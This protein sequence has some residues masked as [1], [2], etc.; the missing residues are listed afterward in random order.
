MA[1]TK[2]FVN[3]QNQSL[4][5]M[6]AYNESFLRVYKY[7]LEKK[8]EKRIAKL[9]KEERD[10]KAKE[11]DK[12]NAEKVNN[13]KKLLEKKVDKKKK[14]YEYK[15]SVNSKRIWEIDFVRGVI[16]LGMLIDHFFFDFIG[17]FT[18]SNF[19]NLPQAFLDINSFASLYWVHP[20]RVTFRLIGIFL[21]FVLSGISAHF[22]RNSMRRSLIVMGA[23]V[24][25]SVA[26]LI[27]SKVT[28]TYEDLVLIGAV[29]G[30]GI[31]MFLYSLYRYAFSHIKGYEKWLKW[32]TLTI[33]LSIL[34][35]WG[36][37]S[38]NA[39]TNRNNFW[40]YYN[41]YAGSI[42]IIRFKDLLPNLGGVILGTKYFGSD[43]VG[44]F[45]ALG[46]TFLGAFIGEFVYKNRKSLL[47]KYNE[48][49]NKATLPIVFMGRYSLWFYLSHQVIYIIIIGAI[50]LLMGAKLA[51]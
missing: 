38:Y 12:I 40:F 8:K 17:L 11:I 13:K 44:L 22:S 50:A 28:G 23:G 43:W 2:S 7:E 6:K 30:I 16:I 10:L 48:K 19:T 37:V 33:A 36:F 29:M 14:H 26:F 35:M 32:L 42:E 41:G 27:V 9:P 1:K 31:C 47:G 3:K 34:I 49:F 18:P 21:L 51:F 24:I 4:E 39:A 20:V 25:I 46:Y 15:N 45:P 5:F